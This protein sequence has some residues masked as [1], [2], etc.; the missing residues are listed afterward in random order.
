M[1]GGQ[2]EKEREVTEVTLHD[3]QSQLCKAMGLLPG[4]LG[5]LSLGTQPLHC[6]EAQAALRGP[7]GKQL[8]LPA[9]SPVGFP[10]NSE[11]Q[12]RSHLSEPSGKFILQLPLNLSQP[13]PN[14]RLVSK[15]KLLLLFK[16]LHF[17]VVTQ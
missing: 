11:H 12:L 1:W 4:S 3:F 7:C 5:T 10:G 14:Y 17:E 9:H 15:V 6:E 2:V 16:P 8:R 13:C